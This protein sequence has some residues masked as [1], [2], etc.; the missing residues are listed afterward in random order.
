MRDL[1]GD[2]YE[3]NLHAENYD[4]DPFRREIAR[5]GGIMLAVTHVVDPAADAGL[6][7]QIT[8]AMREGRIL[9]SWVA[10]QA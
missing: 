2:V 3:S 5:Q 9:C 1:P 6:R 7:R 8:T 10:L 4:T